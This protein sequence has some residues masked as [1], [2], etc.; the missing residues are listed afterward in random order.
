MPK[1]GLFTYAIP[2]S[3]LVSLLLPFLRERTDYCEKT[4]IS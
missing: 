4:G 3:R 1:L 2:L